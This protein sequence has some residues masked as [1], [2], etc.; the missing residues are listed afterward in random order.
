MG[1]VARALK[2]RRLRTHLVCGSTEKDNAAKLSKFDFVQAELH[3]KIVGKTCKTLALR[4]LLTEKTARQIT[5]AQR[6][7]GLGSAGHE[8][9]GNRKRS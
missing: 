3:I 9:S 2:I 4:S 6:K 7:Q 1:R 8:S 5:V